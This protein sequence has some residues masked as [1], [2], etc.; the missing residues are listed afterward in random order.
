MV[1]EFTNE[2]LTDFGNSVQRQAMEASLHDVKSEF[3]REWPLV[4]G[5]EAVTTGAWIESANPCHFSEIVGRV[6]RAG[7]AEADRAL[8]AA[9]AAF[10]D[11][12]RWRPD[13]RARLL[14]E[15]AALL[16]RR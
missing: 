15:A 7:Q 8:K 9:W 14:L 6:A 10:A 16:R 5:G 4:L 3:G 1:P 2:P 11:W 13:E 12:S